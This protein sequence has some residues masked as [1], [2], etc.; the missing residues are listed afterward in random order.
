MKP[1]VAKNLV[2]A[3]IA[4]LAPLLMGS[5]ALADSNN[6]YQWPPNPE[7]INSQHLNSYYGLTI[8]EPAAAPVAS[9]KVKDGQNIL[10]CS[11]LTDNHCLPGAKSSGWDINRVIPNCENS[12]TTDDCIEAINLDTG[13][14]SEMLTS[15][16][17]I[18]PPFGTGYSVDSSSVLGRSGGMGVW[19]SKSEADDQGYA[20]VAVGV[21]HAP[22][23][24]SRFPLQSFAIS[25]QHF[26]VL[27]SD[28]YLGLPGVLDPNCI[29]ET[30]GECAV[31]IPYV[32]G[33]YLTISAHLSHSI[34]AWLSGR[35]LQPKIQIEKMN[36]QYDRVLFGGAPIDVEKVAML[37]PATHS[38]MTYPFDAGYGANQ[39]LAF[40][41][42]DEFANYLNNQSVTEIPLWEVNSVDGGPDIAKCGILGNGLA[43]LVTSNGAIYQSNPPSLES[44]SLAFQIGGLHFSSTGALFHGYYSLLLNKQY[45]NCLYGLK[46]KAPHASVSVIDSKGKPEV[47]ITNYSSN[48][49]W[50]YFSSSGFTFS[51][52]K[53]L[54]KLSN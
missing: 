48:Q 33:T 17:E 37:K 2:L 11:S 28:K 47:S 36:A 14:S 54:V 22:Y 19:K 8:N 15:Q 45:A 5:P 7:S 9:I 42:F 24:A 1:L 50:F 29:W 46:S 25:L 26:R 34:S 30:K 38:K 4:I 51:K 27:R 20:V 32:N 35:L 41:F 40:N 44:G 31:Q 6:F 52:P 49:N 23:G 12:A 21:I 43:A 16:G 39:A 53:I 10:F 18:A 3:S 13:L